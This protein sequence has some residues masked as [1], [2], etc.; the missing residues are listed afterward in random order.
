MS[1]VRILFVQRVAWRAGLPLV[2][3]LAVALAAPAAAQGDSPEDEDEAAAEAAADEATA[4][5]AADE[6]TAEAAP[7]APDPGAE[8]AIEEA[9]EN[10]RNAIEDRPALITLDPTETE[11][12]TEIIAA[13][14]RQLELKLFSNREWKGYWERQVE[15]ATALATA[16]RA[17]D[18]VS[19]RIAGYEDWAALASDKVANQE[20]YFGA[21]QVR[22]DAFEAVLERALDASELEAPAAIPDPSPYQLYLGNLANLQHR[23][24]LQLEAQTRAMEENAF[25]QQNIESLNFV[26]GAMRTDMELARRE[27]AIAEA[28]AELPRDLFRATWRDVSAAAED[29]VEILESD[30]QVSIN[31]QA[32]DEVGRRLVDS[33]I[34][35]RARRIDTLEEQLSAASQRDVMLGAVKDTAIQW[36]KRHAIR[37][38]VILGL[39]ALAV[40]FLAGLVRRGAASLMRR[41]SSEATGDSSRGQRQRTL[42][43]IFTGPIRAAIYVI[44]A[45]VALEQLGVDTGPLLGGAAILGLA[46]SFGSQNLVADLVNGFFILFENQYAV[47]DVIEA[48]GKTG[49]VE[50]ITVRTTWLRSAGTG[51]L[52]VLQNGSIG[53]VSNLTRGFSTVTSHIGVS[54][55]AD[56]DQ[57]RDVTNE[58]GAQMYAEEEWRR[59]LAAAPAWIGVTELGDSAVVFRVQVQTKAGS[60]WPV[61]REL[62]LRIKKRFDEVGIGIPYPQQVVHHVNAPS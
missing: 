40:L 54:Y 41:A 9:L 32:N 11:D 36:F 23:I 35:F 19:P 60:Q 4:E 2:L 6:A 50:K 33:E 5:A 10:W 56:L 30:I 38:A 42:I 44:A 14:L 48:N 28:Q 25:L 57:V 59:V 7:A 13:Q 20:V 62:N 12:E 15:T 55:D 18:P 37:A 39:I 46:I 53:S 34:E 8:A 49:E 22:R 61:E 17:S 43:T 21:L 27:A 26:I 52:H 16:I 58:I 3:L 47:G 24:D 31:E 29:K 51:A 45:L 1:I